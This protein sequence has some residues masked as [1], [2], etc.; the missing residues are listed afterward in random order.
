[1]RNTHNSRT[2]KQL[3]CIE[4]NHGAE[5]L[6]I[7]LDEFLDDEGNTHTYVSMRKWFHGDRGDILP[8]KSGVTIR[9][10]ELLQ[11]GKALRDAYYLLKDDGDSQGR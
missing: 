3:A 2:I 8:T 5:Q 11:V 6:R 7:D 10:G 9:R 4:R 1:M